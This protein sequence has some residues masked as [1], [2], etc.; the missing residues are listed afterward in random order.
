MMKNTT[1]VW[2]QVRYLADDLEPDY[3]VPLHV[4]PIFRTQGALFEQHPLGD[5][6]K[7][8]RRRPPRLLPGAGLRPA[9][10]PDEGAPRPSG[11]FCKLD[12][13]NVMQSWTEP[14]RG[15]GRQGVLA[16]LTFGLSGR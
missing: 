4:V 13:F 7:P 2:G 11:H 16:R 1:Q 6:D 10:A 15:P 8:G 5:A 14:C 9:P 12:P 3:R